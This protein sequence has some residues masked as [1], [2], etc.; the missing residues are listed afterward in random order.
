MTTIQW[1]QQKPS[2][3]HF[4]LL[5][6][7]L[8]ILLSGCV[9]LLWQIHQG[10]NSRADRADVGYIVGPPTLPA[11]TVDKI[12]AEVGSP[13]VGTG[14]VVEQAARQANID[15]AFALA[16][17]WVETNDGEAGVGLNNHNPGAVA[18]SNGFIFYPSYAAAASDWFAVLRSRYV[19][20]G[21]TSVYT[22]CY[23]YVATSHAPEWAAK[24]VSYMQSY[25]GEAPAPTPTPTLDHAPIY[26]QFMPSHET[27]MGENRTAEARMPVATPV[28]QPANGLPVLTGMPMFSTQNSLLPGIGG[29][30]VVL[31]LL[32]VG[33][34]LRRRTL[35]VPAVETVMETVTE[36]L[37]PAVSL[38]PLYVN[39]YSPIAEPAWSPSLP[40]QA[41]LASF[42]NAQPSMRPVQAA[43]EPISSADG[44]SVAEVVGAMASVNGFLHSSASGSILKVDGVP[45]LSFGEPM[46]LAQ[47]PQPS[48]RPAGESG[49]LRARRLVQMSPQGGYPTTEMLPPLSRPG[50][51]LP[52]RL[53]EPVGVGA[54]SS[55]SG[56]APETVSTGAGTRPAGGGLLRRYAQEQAGKQ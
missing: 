39:Q 47:A 8:I 55:S 30:V 5:V 33:F 16:V 25:R 49:K 44:L 56:S 1:L 43:A 36:A 53:A 2:R 45:Q 50:L 42:Q 3:S 10:T 48:P 28:A 26:P 40:W 14:K 7:T 46:Q 13:M 32:L 21:L 20:Q 19:S 9:T 11:E 31:A 12:F 54:A 23:P 37:E 29:L 52:G 27:S 35:M 18:S 41:Q 15:D 51:S 4:V 24:V 6:S 34:R 17:W 38:P 22:I